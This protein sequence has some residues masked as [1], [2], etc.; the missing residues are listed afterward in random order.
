METLFQN[1]HRECYDNIMISV[2]AI[3]DQINLGVFSCRNML[4]DMKQTVMG[5]LQNCIDFQPHCL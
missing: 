5:M 2:L 3:Y 4:E 1:R